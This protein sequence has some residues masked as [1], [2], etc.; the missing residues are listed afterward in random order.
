MEP[1]AVITCPNCG[2]TN[3]PHAALCARCSFALQ[4]APP[5]PPFSN[6]ADN[7]LSSLIPYKNSAALIAYYLGVFS[8]IPVLGFFMAVAA[9]ILG[10]KGL[11]FARERPEARGKT[12]AL[13]GI[14]AGGVIGVIHVV[15][16]VL[17]VFTLTSSRLP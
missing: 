10:I 5:P 9:V 8:I 7:A 17:F 1:A 15:L 3:P 2:A 11:R 12:H 13:V 16:T 4:T 6:G 14:I